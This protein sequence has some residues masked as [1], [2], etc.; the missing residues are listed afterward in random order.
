MQLDP[1]ELGG[2]R[3]PWELGGRRSRAG[4]GVAIGAVAVVPDRNIGNDVAMGPM[5]SVSAAGAAENGGPVARGLKRL[6]G[7]AGHGTGRGYWGLD[8]A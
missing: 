2:R 5:G 1:W 7:C 4:S 8:V 6:E 3:D